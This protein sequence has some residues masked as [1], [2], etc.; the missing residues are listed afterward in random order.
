M[1]Q[2]FSNPEMEA[3]ANANDGDS[4]YILLL[5][6]LVKV[7]KQA[8]K[9][10]ADWVEKNPE[11]ASRLE[12]VVRVLGYI[13]PGMQSQAAMETLMSPLATLVLLTK[14]KLRT[15]CSLHYVYVS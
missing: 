12:T 6:N 15:L 11:Q 2:P 13:V 4:Q 5:R 10:Y 14:V 7:V 3:P 8:P 9:A 1:R